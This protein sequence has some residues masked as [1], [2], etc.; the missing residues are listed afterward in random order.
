MGPDRA[1]ARARANG[2]AS[3]GAG[4][5]P[6]LAILCRAAGAGRRPGGP[7]DGGGR[8]GA[9]PPSLPASPARPSLHLAAAELFERLGRYDDAFDQARLA[10]EATRR[11]YDPA[12]PRRLGLAADPL[13]HARQPQGAAAPTH[14]DRRP[15]LIVGMPRSGTSLVEQILD[16]HALI[17]G[18]GELATLGRFVGSL[19]VSDGPS[20]ATCTPRR[21]TRCRS[22]ANRLGSEYLASLTAGLDPAKSGAL[23]L[24]DKTPLNFYALGLAEV[25]LPG[26]RVIH[27][28]RSPLD[29]CL[30]CYFT[31][32]AF[33]HE[34]SADLS[35]LG[36][37]YRDYRRLMAHWGRVLSLPILDVRYEDLVLD[38]ETEVRR[39]LEF[40]GLP[41][42]D[43]CLQ[44]HKNPRRVATASKSQVRRPLYA[45]SIGRWK[46]YEKHLGDLFDALAGKDHAA[47][48]SGESRRPSATQRAGGVRSI[49]TSLAASCP[50]LRESI[51]ACH[52]TGE[53]TSR[54]THSHSPHK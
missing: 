31:R 24:T 37:F 50:T 52:L 16:S 27:C 7:G 41:W 38:V 20:G 48:G 25:L 33:G 49:S 30:S 3:A 43:R 40:L 21:W 18:R 10:N 54:V 15:V 44:F 47:G 8:R 42:D 45:T 39:L 5:D 4:A 29:S 46:H 53:R 23:C 11:P 28:V 17:A 36:A 6:Q 51:P 12:A 9:P 22:A 14:G 13:L 35:H 1:D 32:F 26:C 19:S 2:A 34:F